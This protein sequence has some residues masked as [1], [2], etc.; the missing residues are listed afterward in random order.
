MTSLSIDTKSLDW[1]SIASQLD[2][3]GY[4]IAPGLLAPKQAQVLMHQV[5]AYASSLCHVSLSSCN[6]G[7]DDL[8]LFGKP[9]SE[10]LA[11]WREALYAHLVPIA[12]RVRSGQRIGLEL[13]FHDAP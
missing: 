13:S 9:L 6:L 2:V 1:A 10:P 4:A 11:A 7:R 5:D 12:S 8:H 3:E